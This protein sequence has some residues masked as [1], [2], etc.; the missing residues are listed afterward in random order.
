MSMSLWLGEYNVASIL[1]PYNEY[2]SPI[3]RLSMIHGKIQ[4]NHGN[5]LPERTQTQRQYI[6]FSII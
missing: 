5:M 3:K 1:Y 4:M 2:Y 6:L